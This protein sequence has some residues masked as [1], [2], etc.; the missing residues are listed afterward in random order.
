MR[1]SP[2]GIKLVQEFEGCLK[3]QPDGTYAPYICP[4][5]VLTIGWGHTNHHGRKFDRSA[6]WTQAEC[7]AE[8][9]SDLRGFERA[10]ESRVKVP[11][12]QS[13]F[14]ALVSFTYNCG[15]GNLAK[16]TLLRK[17]NAHDYIGAA[18]QFAA[19]NKGGGRVL[20][21][22]T[23]RRAAERTLFLAD[24]L[25]SAAPV[26][27]VDESTSTRVDTPEDAPE[28]PDFL[29]KRKEEPEER[30]ETMVEQG[31]SLLRSK[32]SWLLTL[33]GG[34]AASSTAA[35]DDTLLDLALGLATRPRFWII[36]AVIG[37][38]GT[39]LYF[40]WKNHGKGSER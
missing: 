16:S 35:G 6:R 21:G 1:I 7:D 4:A 32:T 28:V 27:L 34:T 17:L 18:N 8:L 29:R 5:G 26:P 11:L 22:L 14:D 39:G 23:R 3:R 33:L 20:A 30:E 2:R 36:V 15:E 24:G 12:T 31:K 19:W 10:V 13:M 37:L 9:A 40:Y 38:V 25:P